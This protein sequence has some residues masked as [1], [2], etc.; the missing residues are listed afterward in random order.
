MVRGTARR[1]RSDGMHPF[2]ELLAVLKSNEAFATGS[3]RP[4]LPD[5]VKVVTRNK[6]NGSQPNDIIART[7]D[8]INHRAGDHEIALIDFDRKGMPVDVA[9]KL[10]AAGGF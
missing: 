9:I 1:F 2:G 4:D 7:Q 3:M 10:E 6:L 5:Q 8:F